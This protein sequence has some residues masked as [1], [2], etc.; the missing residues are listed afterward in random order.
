MYYLNGMIDPVRQIPCTV[1]WSDSLLIT[2]K[3]T[4]AGG[5]YQIDSMLEVFSDDQVGQPRSSRSMTF[6]LIVVF[7]CALTAGCRH[8]GAMQLR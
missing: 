3:P 2:V 5:R 8:D 1:V 6:Q 4:G 7:V